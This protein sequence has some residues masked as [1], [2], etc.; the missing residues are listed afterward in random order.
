MGLGVGLG[1]AW[2][3]VALLAQ[4]GICLGY[5]KFFRKEQISKP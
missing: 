2:F 3:W 1:K 5:L 4:L